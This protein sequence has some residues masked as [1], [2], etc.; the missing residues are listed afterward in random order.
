VVDHLKEA[1]DRCLQFQVTDD[2]EREA[3]LYEL[4]QKP[5]VPPCAV[6]IGV[7]LDEQ[8]IRNS[9]L[10]VQESATARK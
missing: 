5:V 2:N 10:E 3:Y 4:N 9:L 8:D 6:L 1:H 7:N